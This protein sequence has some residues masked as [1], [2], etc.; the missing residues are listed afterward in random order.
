MILWF[1]NTVFLILIFRSF[2][3]NDGV[4]DFIEVLKFSFNLNCFFGLLAASVIAGLRFLGSI[5]RLYKVLLDLYVRKCSVLS[6][7][8]EM[9]P[10]DGNTV[11]PYYMGLN[12]LLNESVQKYTSIL[13]YTVTRIDL[14]RRYI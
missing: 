2:L 1:F 11:A 12:N 13:N 4:T 6:R 9:S 14:R 3:T 5:P 10:V 7:S 8:L